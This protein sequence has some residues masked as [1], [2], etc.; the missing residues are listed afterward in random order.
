MNDK[1][2]TE[3]QRMRPLEIICF[4]GEDWW[5][6]N[7]GHIDMQLMRRFSRMG[8]VVY[9]NSIVMQKPRLA[10]TGKFL[11]K[12]I[13]KTKSIFTGLKK[14]DAGF[15]VFSP[16]SLPVHHIAWAKG[17]NRFML[18]CQIGRIIRK[19]EI[20]NPVVW[21]ACPAACDVA[22]N[23]NKSK[24]VYQRTDRFEEYPNVDGAVVSEYDRKLKQ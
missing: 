2:F 14:T 17:F 23:M 10:Q 12:L 7:R 20:K 24:L 16:F 6:H 8:T 13:R 15:W 19:F 1:V 4:G 22:L 21:V 18:D 9:I 5:Y 3:S 11:Q